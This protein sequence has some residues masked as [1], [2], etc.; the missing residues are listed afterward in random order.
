MKEQ[1][2]EIHNTE[3]LK[4]YIKAGALFSVGFQHEHIVIRKIQDHGFIWW[5]QTG[6]CY[7]DGLD[8]VY[9]KDIN[10]TQQEPILAYR[11]LDD[12][13]LNRALRDIIYFLMFD[14]EVEREMKENQEDRVNASLH[15]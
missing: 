6:D 14:E 9:Y 11:Y 10:W 8:V 13:K 12:D 2:V 7:M 1:W 5:C 4:K 15:T 3:E